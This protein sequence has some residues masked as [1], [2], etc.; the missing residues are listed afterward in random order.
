MHGRWLLADLFEEVRQTKEFWPV[1]GKYPADS[2]LEIEIFPES[3]TLSGWHESLNTTKYSIVHANRLKIGNSY[4]LEYLPDQDKIIFS[5]YDGEQIAWQHTYAR[6]SDKR[7]FPEMQKL[8]DYIS[9]VCLQGHYTNLQTGKQIEISRNRLGKL[10]Y[11]LITRPDHMCGKW[12][13][14]E[15]AIDGAYKLAAW[16]WQG[17]KLSIY[18][19]LRTRGPEGCMHFKKGALLKALRFRKK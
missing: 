4:L 8:D 18:R 13:W 15:I 14:L 16:E 5:D 19:L 6:H 7:P 12:N 10:P 11:R 3:I 1:A 17:D 2:F 9:R